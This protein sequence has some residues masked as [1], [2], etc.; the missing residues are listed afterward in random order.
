MNHELLDKIKFDENGL[1]P[2]ILQEAFTSRILM[3]AYMNRESLEKSLATG[4]CWFYSRSRKQ[5]WEKG[6]TSGS[7]QFIE[8]IRPDCD[9]DT[10]LIEVRA[11]GPAC[12]T[13]APGCFDNEKTNEEAIP[14]SFFSMVA[15]LAALIHQRRLEKPEGS[16]TTRL[17]E[18]GVK[19]IAQKVG[20]EG[21]EVALAGVSE[22]DDRLVEE[23]AD[24]IYHL[25]VLLEERGLSLDKVGEILQQRAGKKP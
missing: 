23:T 4:H 19:K 12:H 3:L 8:N 7:Y 25:L 16:Y 10:L 22:N 6:A 13:G 14:T 21:L 18:S 2:A 20:E 15:R 9:G 17:F 1:I 24:L 11:A 5:L